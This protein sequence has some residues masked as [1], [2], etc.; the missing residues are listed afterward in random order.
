MYLLI[1]P[2]GPTIFRWG[3]VSSILISGSINTGYYEPLPLPSTI[4][5]FVKYSLIINGIIKENE[6]NNEPVIKG[7]LFYVEG[8]KETALGV[9]LYP[10]KLIC[11]NK[12]AFNVI[13]INEDFYNHRIGIGLDSGR[14]ITKEGYIYMEK[15]LDLQSI[16]NKVIRDKV[17]RYGILVQ[18]SLDDKFEHK[19][20]GFVAPFGGESR[21]AKIQ[22]IDEDVVDKAIKLHKRLL[23]S[24]AIIDEGE[25]NKIKW[26]NHDEV[27]ICAIENKITYR[28]I[29]LG[30]ERAKRLPMKLALM[31]T[32]EVSGV[33]NNSVFQAGV[34][35][36][37]SKGW[38]TVCQI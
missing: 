38:G 35:Y 22:V 7:P 31:P 37:T 11:N 5:G 6:E 10:S 34:G 32:V 9:H 18:V 33:S 24:P 17:K 4:Y 8:E 20:N 15:L 3:G 36:F 13:N 28:V 25:D 26:N 21:L 14:K 30:F 23:C 12:D 16:A 2:I 19:I 29:S 1:T 27:S